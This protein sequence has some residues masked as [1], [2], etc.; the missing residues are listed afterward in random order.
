MRRIDQERGGWKIAASLSRHGIEDTARIT[1]SGRVAATSDVVLLTG[2]GAFIL[3]PEPAM[4]I[5][6]SIGV[7]WV[8]L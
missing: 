7:D 1:A 2:T 6:Q 3:H 8:D 4:A 5:E